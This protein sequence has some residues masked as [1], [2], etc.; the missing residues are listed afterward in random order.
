VRIFQVG[1]N[2]DQWSSPR[3]CCGWFGG[4]A[5]LTPYYLCVDDIRNFHQHYFDLCS[6]FDN[7]NGETNKFDY[8]AMKQACDDYFYLPARSEHRGTGGI[9]FD[10]V[11]ANDESRSFVQD[12]ARSWMPSWIPI[13]QRRNAMAYT[14]EQKHWQKLRRGRYLEFNL[15]YDV[16]LLCCK[17]TA[18]MYTHSYM[19]SLY[20]PYPCL[21]R[22]QVWSPNCQSARGRGH[23]I[24][25]ARNRLCVQSSRRAKLAGSNIAGHSRKAHRLDLLSRQEGEGS[26]ND[27]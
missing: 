5:D 3:A 13:V 2:D 21:A 6:R 15:L 9:F 23:G 4:G 8:Y 19:S 16:S 25:P 18:T 7:E 14:D 10:D 22:G 20:S 1:D 12:V 11:V 27:V 26:V 24:G 17:A